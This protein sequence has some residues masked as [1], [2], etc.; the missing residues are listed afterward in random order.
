MK[1]KF[2]KNSESSENI[3]SFSIKGFTNFSFI[4]VLIILSL[5]QAQA[6]PGDL[7][8]TFGVDGTV[9]VDSGLKLNDSA[10]AVAAQPDGKVVV[11]GVSSITSTG[12][13]FF[14]IRLNSNGT[15]DTTFNNSGRLTFN[16]NNNS[17]GADIARAVA[18]QSDGKIVVAG[19]SAISGAGSDI[20]VARLNSDGTF[21]LSFDGDGKVI[22]NLTGNRNEYGRA[23]VLQ[24]DGKIVV[25][26]YSNR[27]TT[28]DDFV[29]VRYNP[30]GSLDTTFNASGIVT[31]DILVNREDR[32]ASVTL[33]P[34]GKIV[35][36]GYT[37]D[38][39]FGNNFAIVRYNTDG[40]LD[41]GFN[42]TGKVTADLNLNSSDFGNSVT[43]QT[44][45]KII[46]AGESSSDFGIAR[47]SS[48]GVLDT[49]FGGD[50]IVTTNFGTNS[51]DTVRGVVVQSNGKIT[52]AGKSRT[53]LAFAQYNTDGTLDTTFDGNGLLVQNAGN[54]QLSAFG[55]YWGMVLQTDGKIV[56]VGDGWRD[57][58]RND[59]T[60]SRIN[61]NGTFDFA[62]GGGDGITSTDINKAN[63]EVANIAIQPDGKIVAV[64]RAQNSKGGYD[65]AVTRYNP[66]GTLD[67]S[68]G[69]NG[70]VITDILGHP[71]EG[72]QA[73]AIQP[74][75]KIVIA[76]QTD[77]ASD[78]ALSDGAL[79]RYNSNG[80]LDTMFGAGGI[81]IT[82]GN[83]VA[84][85]L[86]W[87]YPLDITLQP[88]RKIVVAGQADYV[89]ISAD[90]YVARYNSNG[91]LDGSFI[92]NVP[93]HTP[94][95]S[96]VVNYGNSNVYN[97]VNTVKL[98]PDGK[99]VVIG[100]TN[101]TSNGGPATD[102]ALARLNT[103]GSLD[104][105]FDS[106]GKV[107][108]D[109]GNNT[110]DF[111]NDVE[112]QSDGKI[113]AVGQTNINSIDM[114]VARYNA[115]G[116]LDTS[117]GGGDGKLNL[118]FNTWADVASGV[119][120]QPDGKIILGG[121]ADLERNFGGFALVRL[122]P[123]GTFDTSFG[124]GTGRL[125]T[126]L[127]EGVNTGLAY[128][129]NDM[130]LQ[131]DGKI[132]LA[133]RCS[134][135]STGRD[136]TLVRY[137]NSTPP[138]TLFDFDGDSKTDIGIFRPASG[139]WW[140]NG[141]SSGQTVAAQFGSSSDKI[142]PADFTGDG[143]TDIAF[144]RPASGEWF[145]LR[146]EDGSFFSF[147]FGTTGDVPLTGDFDADGKT[148]PTIFRPSTNEWFVSKSTGGTII[149]TFGTTG[150]VPVVAD[151]DGDS[152]TDIAVY[153]PSL[154]QWWIQRS[155][156]SSVYAFQFGT[157]S[158]KPVQGDYT[159]DSKADIAF[160]RPSTGEWFILR[161]EDSSFYSVPFGTTGDIASPGDYDGDGKFDTAVF[162]P[163]NATWF[164]N[165]TTAGILITNFGTTGDKPIPGSLVP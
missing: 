137:Q 66:N 61:G 58:S 55:G 139:E 115:N 153:R 86:V 50:G 100:Y 134:F 67:T 3:D 133:G 113:I 117:F 161:S 146:S 28:G 21:D 27:I 75:G 119:A 59:L 158:D 164:I 25:S 63:D 23:V 65:F 69:G 125:I 87:L 73:I 88:D 37:N 62:F 148:D 70:I 104:T 152:K 54:N 108:T 36:A 123:G 41:A 47:F 39:S 79:I 38:P 78:G 94:N 122:T 82:P 109:F 84:N 49:T 129:I 105:S 144:W 138:R 89:S 116:S 96:V 68:F 126:N 7:D 98:Q 128:A 42:G 14:V 141:S 165:R 163:S 159:G 99:I 106:D 154:G 72:G 135:N 46:I 52:V 102:M 1:N 157:S 74:D 145:I 93:N 32:G 35:V 162:R 132:I 19:E 85:G 156:N 77:N 81:V 8:L 110:A 147:P 12:Q 127:G 31:T 44:D 9:Q 118:D 10:Y 155:S 101:V 11:V 2:R 22:T 71:D 30:N 131:S 43:L 13:D 120:V 140:I 90:G 112:I 53:E 103:N 107:V 26:G 24:S 51:S 15:L 160:F 150:D 92:T 136:F 18:I 29:V 5:I 17:T 121:Y 20:V 4:I 142:V 80:T 56:A 57:F 6:A 16:F 91:S 124:N 95:G 130:V 97:S 60:V 48:N 111:G 40:A 64:G 33:Q 114:A 151:Y 149:T 45:G 143:K 76:G 83:L 34:D